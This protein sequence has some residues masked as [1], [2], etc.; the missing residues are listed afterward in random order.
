MNRKDFN[1]I[2]EK[3]IQRVQDNLL[4]K[5]DEY[6]DNV[7]VFRNFESAAR[8]IGTTRE[9]ALRG[10]WLKHRVS[11]DDMIEGK[12]LYDAPMIYEKIGDNLAYS[13]LL[14]AMFLENTEN[15]S[16]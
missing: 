10:M 6:A 7:N 8:Q 1:V 14:A 4:H 5:G 15:R 3:F 13:I 16:L 11:I 2:V 12:L 9:D